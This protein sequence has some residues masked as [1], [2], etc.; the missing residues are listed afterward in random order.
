MYDKIL[1]GY[2]TFIDCCA[3]EEL[4]IYDI[5]DFCNAWQE[6]DTKRSLCECIGLPFDDFKELG[7]DKVNI[8]KKLSEHMLKVKA[9]Y[10]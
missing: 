4:S 9:Y 2:A 10:R 8:Y 5:D 6:S 1:F 3:R 7:D